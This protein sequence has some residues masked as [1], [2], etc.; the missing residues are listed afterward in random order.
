M[1]KNHA[2]SAEIARGRGSHTAMPKSQIDNAPHKN[3][4]LK[5]RLPTIKGA[6]RQGMP[7]TCAD[8]IHARDRPPASSS[9][10]QYRPVM[11]A[12][13]GKS[14][15]DQ[16]RQ[17]APRVGTHW[18]KK[19]RRPC[20]RYLAITIKDAAHVPFHP[21]RARKQ[22]RPDD[23]AADQRNASPASEKI[24]A[25]YVGL[26]ATTRQIRCLFANTAPRR[27]PGKAPGR[28]QRRVAPRA[29]PQSISPSRTEAKI[30]AR[31]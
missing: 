3:K 11:A 21:F 16:Q 20:A 29:V 30:D 12:G 28:K 10:I 23:S 1:W 24:L 8:S 5:S 7:N 2:A 18:R 25:T 26:D 4:S 15:R 14:N 17:S 31:Q 9:H 27:R 19:N 13:S 6:E 22:T